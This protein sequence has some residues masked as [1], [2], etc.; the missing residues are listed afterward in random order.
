MDPH[1]VSLSDGCAGSS[2][3]VEHLPS[4]LTARPADIVAM[5]LA[6]SDPL[7]ALEAELVRRALDEA[8]G[9]REAAAKRL[10]VSRTTLWRKR[11]RIADAQ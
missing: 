4:E 11:R 3:E 8:G 1:T 2:I 7:A 10:G 6:A 9:S 5:A